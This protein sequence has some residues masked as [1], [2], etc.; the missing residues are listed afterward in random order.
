MAVPEELM[1]I[2]RCIECRGGLD[3]HGDRLVCR[4][5]GVAYPV[6][7]D[8]PVMMPEQIIRPDEREKP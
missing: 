4:D 8:I 5:C 3:D 6:Q 2:L 1:A 7:G